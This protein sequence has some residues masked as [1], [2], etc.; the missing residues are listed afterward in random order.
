MNKHLASFRREKNKPGCSVRVHVE[1]YAYSLAVVR[2]GHGGGDSL[3]PKIVCRIV[4]PQLTVG[5]IVEH[6]QVSD[7]SE[8]G[9]RIDQHLVAPARQETVDIP[10]RLVPPAVHNQS[11]QEAHVKE[12]VRLVLQPK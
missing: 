10:S 2:V 1:D 9:W 12:D 6:V 3:P 11:L 5:E 7:E 4:T 8:R